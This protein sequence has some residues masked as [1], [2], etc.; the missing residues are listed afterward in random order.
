MAVTTIPDE[1]ISDEFTDVEDEDDDDDEDDD[2]DE[3][4]TVGESKRGRATSYEDAEQRFTASMQKQLRKYQ[5]S[6]QVRLNDRKKLLETRLR[7]KLDEWAM[8]HVGTAQVS[9][10]EAVAESL[11]RQ[12]EAAE[13]RMQ[14]FRE[15]LKQLQE[16]GVNVSAVQERLA[17]AGTQS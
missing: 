17:G 5:K 2:E 9:N 12:V 6:L 14:Q 15:Q 11:I 13:A 8:A 3:A 4:T 1:E 7:N 16:A 10:P